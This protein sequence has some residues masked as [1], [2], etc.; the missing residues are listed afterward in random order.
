MFRIG[1]KLYR[2]K[3]RFKGTEIIIKTNSILEKFIIV[4][5]D[6]NNINNNK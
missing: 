4:N 1:S 6:N 5:I 2:P 3:Q